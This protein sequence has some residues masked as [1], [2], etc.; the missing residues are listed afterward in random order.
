MAADHLSY[1][2]RSFQIRSLPEAVNPDTIIW[3]PVLPDYPIRNRYSPLF[4][5]RA[6]ISWIEP[7]V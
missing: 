3:P 6:Q 2:V 4:D 5:I 1:R 7:D